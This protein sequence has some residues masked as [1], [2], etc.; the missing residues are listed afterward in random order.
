[1]KGIGNRCVW[2]INEEQEIVEQKSA[3]CTVHVFERTEGCS[4]C[5]AH[6]E[7]TNQKRS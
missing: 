4:P 7:Q 2:F 1:M 5:M 6:V 3:V